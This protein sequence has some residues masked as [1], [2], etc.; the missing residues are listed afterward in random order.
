[1]VERHSSRNF[2]LIYKMPMTLE[3]AIEQITLSKKVKNSYMIS[4]KHN[5]RKIAQVKRGIF[6]SIRA[7]KKY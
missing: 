2:V 6:L 3:V 7:L 4:T 1:M 5:K